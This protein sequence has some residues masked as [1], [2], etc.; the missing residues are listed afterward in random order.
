LLP[1]FEPG[2]DG[3]NFAKHGLPGVE[4]RL[5]EIPE[6]KIFGKLNAPFRD[7]G[8]TPVR[9]ITLRKTKGKTT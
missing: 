6:P 3:K 4:S 8:E 7:A 9:K 1:Y 5:P 2:K